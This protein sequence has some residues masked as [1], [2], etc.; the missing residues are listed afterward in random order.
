MKLIFL[1]YASVLAVQ[2]LH[3]NE[4]M[5]SVVMLKNEA[6]KSFFIVIVVMVSGIFSACHKEDDPNDPGNKTLVGKWKYVEQYSCTGAAGSWNPALPAGQI[7]QF[8]GD[9]SFVPAAEFL[10]SANRYRILD[11]TRIEL[12]PVVSTS[13]YVI[14]SY[15]LSDNS[16]ELIL[17]PLFPSICIEGCASKFIRE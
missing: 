9:S 5:T 15:R 13:G 3:R 17:S 11:S 1:D 2:M 7:I 16:K 8:K 6:M 14:M 4:K 10:L 12:S